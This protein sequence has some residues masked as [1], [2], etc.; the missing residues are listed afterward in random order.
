MSGTTHDTG[1]VRTI[2]VTRRLRLSRKTCQQCGARFEGPA[3]QKHCSRRC[4]Q[5]LSYRRHAE[6]RRAARRGKYH[7]QKAAKQKSPTPRKRTSGAPQA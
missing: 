6:A 5:I 2:T 3:V 4:S 1:T 7:Q